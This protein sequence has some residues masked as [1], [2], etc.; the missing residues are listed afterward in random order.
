M[1]IRILK[2]ET[3]L[4][5]LSHTFSTS[6][7]PQ[8]M[9]LL[10]PVDSPTTISTTFKS[11][12]KLFSTISLIWQPYTPS[13]TKSQPRHAELLR[14]ASIS[15]ACCSTPVLRGR[16]EGGDP[17]SMKQYHAYYDRVGCR[18]NIDERKSATC[19]FGNGS[20]KSQGVAQISFPLI[21]LTIKF[22]TRILRDAVVPLRIC[23]DE[24]DR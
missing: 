16:G 6:M 14:I 11:F 21:A 3:Q 1:V 13:L 22:Y 18:L 17:G 23:I 5:I 7:S 4:M 12:S 9:L 24:M 10:K 15:E 19:Y 20:E 8:M 2:N